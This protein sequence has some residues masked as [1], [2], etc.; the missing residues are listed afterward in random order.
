MS[1]WKNSVIWKNNSATVIKIWHFYKPRHHL[2][3]DIVNKAFY[4]DEG[5]FWQYSFN[6]QALR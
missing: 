2:R 3:Q 5:C 4:A 1:V 6:S